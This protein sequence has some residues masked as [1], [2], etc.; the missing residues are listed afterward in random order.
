MYVNVRDLPALRSAVWAAGTQA[1]VA[2]QAGMTPSR[3]SQL[4]SGHHPAVAL[5][6]AAALEDTLKVERGTLFAVKD[7][8]L[9]APYMAMQTA[10]A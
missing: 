1:E 10:A 3:M 5:E 7:R 9:A 8:E 6:R 2:V 4:L